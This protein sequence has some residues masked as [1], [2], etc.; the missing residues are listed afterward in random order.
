VTS[1]TAWSQ[2]ILFRLNHVH[3]PALS[4]I[5]IEKIVADIMRTTRLDEAMA[6][7]RAID[8]SGMG[9]EDAQG[10]SLA[11]EVVAQRFLLHQ[12]RRIA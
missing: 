9:S 4:L 12:G 2:E 3:D 5:A 11:L 6:C 1:S 10:M 8:S 7:Y